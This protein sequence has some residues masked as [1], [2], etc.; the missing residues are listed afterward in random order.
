MF[1]ELHLL[2]NFAPSNLNRDDTGSPKT[3][4]FGGYPRARISSQCLKRNIRM[5]FKDDKLLPP[6]ALASRTKRLVEEVAE[7]LE[8][9]HGRANEQARKVVEAALAGVKIR[10]ANGGKT[11]Y[12]LFL[13]E[14]EIRQLVALCQEHWD[15]L[16][17]LGGVQEEEKLGERGAKKA[18]KAA[19]P[20][21]VRKAL[22]AL[23]DGG[24]A[25]DVATML[26]VG[27][28]PP[29]PGTPRLMYEAQIAVKISAVGGILSTY[30]LGLDVPPDQAAKPARLSLTPAQAGRSMRVRMGS[31]SAWRR[32]RGAPRR[33]TR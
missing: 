1:V 11:Q 28:N 8:K 6:E 13:G 2:Q 30:S 7:R 3:A 25:A 14:R 4:I 19:V 20:D 16:L 23:L 26:F 17:G 29:E 32:S 18:A 22:Q 31:I 9:Q 27:V 33:S 10:L 12:L 15:A 24:K 21:E 5:A